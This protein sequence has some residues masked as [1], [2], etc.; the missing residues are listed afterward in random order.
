MRSDRFYRQ[1]GLG[2]SFRMPPTK[3]VDVFRS[4]LAIEETPSRGVATSAR[5][6]RTGVGDGALELEIVVRKLFCKTS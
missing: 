3:L 5:A 4:F 2:S 1:A 6:R